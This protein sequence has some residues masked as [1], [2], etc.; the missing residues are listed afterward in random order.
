MKPRLTGPNFPIS[1]YLQDQL[2]NPDVPRDT[3]IDILNWFDQFEYRSFTVQEA[4][5]EH[6]KDLHWEGE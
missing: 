5:V 3:K 6:A 2:D 4:L 1:I